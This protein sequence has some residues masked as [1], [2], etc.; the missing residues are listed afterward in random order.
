[1]P[2]PKPILKHS[3]R[4]LKEN[5]A[6]ISIASSADGKNELPLN[7]FFALLRQNN[8]LVTPK[9]I[10]DSHTLIQHYSA[11]VKNEREL[12]NYLSPIFA[13]SQEEQVQFGELFEQCFFERDKHII[14]GPAEEKYGWKKVISHVTRHWW[15]YLVTLLSG[16]L[17]LKLLLKNE[18]YLPPWKK[19]TMFL[20]ATVADSVAGSEKNGAVRS[21]RAEVRITGL[22][23][24]KGR[25]QRILLKTRYD[26]GDKTPQ[27]TN[28]YHNYRAEGRYTVTAYAEIFF[29]NKLQFRDTASDDVLICF[30]TRNISI[31]KSFAGD[32]VKIGEKISFEALSGIKYADSLRWMIT[33][34]GQFIEKGI[35]RR[36]AL[37]FNEEGQQTV[38]CEPLVKDKDAYCTVYPS[39]SFFVYD[40]QPKPLIA[41]R[42][43]ADAK[44]ITFL[45]R[46]KP[47]WI[48]IGIWAAALSLIF[49]TLFKWLRNKLQKRKSTAGREAKSEYE[50]LIQSFTG[51]EGPV[52]LPFA[53]KN[54]LPLPEVEISELSRAMR[55]RIKDDI[56]YL[57]LLKTIGKAVENGGFFV[58]VYATATQQ[59]E[60]LVLI[61]ENHPNSQ[62]VKLVEYL[63]ELLGKQNVFIEKFYYRQDPGTC[64]PGP[65]QTG[66][67]GLEKLHEKYSKHILLIFGDAYQ[68]LYHLYP[69]MDAQYLRL[70]NRWQYKAVVTPVSFLDWGN[71]EKKALLDE[72]PVLPVDIP[73][74]LLL[75]QKLFS[76]DINVL[77]EL[78][79]YQ[80][81]F[82]ESATV[83]F[84]DADELYEYCE[85]AEWAR[86]EGE[87]E[88]SNILFQWL[89][90]LAVYPKIRWQLTLGVGKALLDK[91]HKT[92]E[93]NFTTLL[94]IARIKWMKNGRFP[95]YTRL[96]LLKRLK[97]E[98]EI[99][100]RETI[101]TLLKEIPETDV[102][103]NHFTYEEKE[104]QRLVNEFN[105]YAHDPVKYAAYKNSKDIFEQFNEHKK[106]TDI[107]TQ[108]YLQ[109]QELKWTT[110]INRPKRAGTKLTEPANIP[111]DTYF[112]N[113]QDD[114]TVLKRIYS[115]LTR[116]SLLLL[117][118]SLIGLAGLFVL[119]RYGK[120]DLPP[121]TALKTF[122]QAIKIKYTVPQRPFH[123]YEVLL[124]MGDSSTSL[125]SNS[126]S[127]LSLPIN[128]SAKIISVVEVDGRQVFDTA[129]QIRHDKYE[130]ILT[131]DSLSTPPKPDT[132]KIA[133]VNP[134]TAN[135]PVSL[136]EIW[137]G[138]TNNRLL[139]IDLR[140]NLLYYSTGGRNTY[141][142][143]RIN[144]VT[145]YASG[146]YKVIS[147][148]N[149][150]YYIFFVKSVVGNSF[151]FAA[152]QS[153]VTSLDAAQKIDETTCNNFDAMS[154]YYD[155]SNADNIYLPVL[156]VN[157]QARAL[158]ASEAAKLAQKLKQFDAENNRLTIDYHNN[159]RLLSPYSEDMLA[160]FFA[161]DPQG[162]KATVISRASRLVFYVNVNFRTRDDNAD[163]PLNRGF[164]T[165]DIIVPDDRDRN[166][167]Q[168]QQQQ[169]QQTASND[170]KQDNNNNIDPITTKNDAD[171][172]L[173][174]NDS[175][176]NTSA[177]DML[178]KFSYE[179][180]I[181]GANNR[182]IAY[183]SKNKYRFII[184]DLGANFK[185]K[186][187]ETGLDFLEQLP[188]NISK[189]AVIIYTT[190]QWEKKY[191]GQLKK[192]GFRQIVTNENELLRLIEKSNR[193][194]ASSN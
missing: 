175:P 87:E 97:V 185:M 55:Q 133:I 89:A 156:S 190:S 6:H 169:Q 104:T 30:G 170:Q 37:S 107:P 103:D 66:G 139:N 35:G 166:N 160:A 125:Y 179:V 152:C 113:N 130:V 60:Y 56:S 153:R 168:Q 5:S 41:M 167:Q 24:L 48:K 8:F 32:S 180:D 177:E 119:W 191:Y 9:Q 112:G 148:A 14:V 73:G 99:V 131:A 136:H 118:L 144:N 22:D 7:D 53:T 183:L 102:N 127:T 192:L 69:V 26:W 40:T 64:Y 86:I 51:K 59:S 187:D 128:D 126:I 138:R 31:Q 82:Y 38:Y 143:Y 173:W 186:T 155:K 114:H 134:K 50:K 4:K 121:L 147:A 81:E 159:A 19:P 150:A 39:I 137:Q 62:Q 178:R 123:K 189:D 57:H 120:T 16:I 72:L 122:K 101:L 21:K 70:I 92:P 100:A 140:K 109:N 91:Y 67:I 193:P 71:K 151:Q 161:R 65:A 79:Q 163:N 174:V 20:A 23:S 52:D 154:L 76:E 17:V 1:L 75:M 74:L 47:V 94:R 110:M 132:P 34:D 58:P 164:I 28:S 83:D 172:I 84:E 49:A 98:N 63:L 29:K 181:T 46:V 171:R 111:L 157:G 13:N 45:Y 33:K 116:V 44:P 135:L 115:V 149:G 43:A 176:D 162:K 18:P 142:T 11:L 36:I 194:K 165:I 145:R 184:V 146:T 182:A 90:A 124:R 68:L 80:H 61:D 158:A 85:L 15:K 88:N 96:E 188:Q 108:A 10:T 117:V 106:L 93:L 78:K 105:L 95:D 42:V 77:A 141:G 3:K 12:C 54:Y 27:D 2:K 129:L 25:Y